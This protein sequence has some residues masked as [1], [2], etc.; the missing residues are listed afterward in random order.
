MHNPH[1]VAHKSLP[2]GTKVKFTNLETGATITATVQDRGPYKRGREFDLSYG[3]A[4][5]LGTVKKGVAQL[6]AEIV[7][8]DI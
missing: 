3:A 1:V 5:K 7:H 6:R 8:R 4:K 2:F